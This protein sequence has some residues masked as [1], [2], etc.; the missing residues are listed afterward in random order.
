V[1][2][3]DVPTDSEAYVHRIGRT[4]RAGRSGE[5]ILFISPRDQNFLRMV[6]RETRQP[7]EEMEQPSVASINELRVTRFKQRIS[8][9]LESKQVEF[10]ARLLEQYQQ[11]TEIPPLQIAAALA[12]LV[13]GE[14]PLLLDEMPRHN[15]SNKRRDSFQERDSAE[16]SRPR[17]S[18]TPR[19]EGPMDKYRVEVGRNHGAKPGNI[20]GA[21]ANEAGIDSCYIGGIKACQQNCCEC[22]SEPGFRDAN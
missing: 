2:N 19:S 5:A 14:R 10:F 9:A 13:Q 20:V 8:E 18:Q 6:Q 17:R 15:T 3:Y 11:E 12:T 4:G 21:I 22:S 1:I 7:I 16:N